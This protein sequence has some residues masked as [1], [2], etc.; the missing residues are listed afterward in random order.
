L[1]D[2]PQQLLNEYNIKVNKIESNYCLQYEYAHDNK[3]YNMREGLDTY[4]EDY[5]K[6]D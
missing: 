5:V 6:H 2:L 1:I 3:L 4:I